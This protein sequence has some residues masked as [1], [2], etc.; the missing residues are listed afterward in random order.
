MS[1]TDNTAIQV[2]FVYTSPL[3]SAMNSQGCSFLNKIEN[4]GYQATLF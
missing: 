4:V 1:V 2:T 3:L